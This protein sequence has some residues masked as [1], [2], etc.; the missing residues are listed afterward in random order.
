[1]HIKSDQ[2]QLT[3]LN[4][5]KDLAGFQYLQLLTIYFVSNQHPEEKEVAEFVMCI[6]LSCP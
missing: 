4:D 3:G 5:S 1:M 2:S 6:S